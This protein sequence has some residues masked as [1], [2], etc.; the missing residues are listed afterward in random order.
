[1]KNIFIRYT[2]ALIAVLLS[3]FLLLLLIPITLYGGYFLLKIFYNV[4]IIENAIIVSD[5]SFSIISACTALIAYILLTVLILTT[6]KITLKE[7]IKLFFIGSLG[8]YLMNI[9]RIFILIAIYLEYGKNYFEAVHLVFWHLVSTLIVALIWIVL[10]EYYKI[11]SIPVYSD[12]K[13]IT[14]HLGKR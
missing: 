11:K 6:R 5:Y 7:R 2:L 13:F 10:V 3:N 12:I 9:L 1:M 4:S 8:I 14:L